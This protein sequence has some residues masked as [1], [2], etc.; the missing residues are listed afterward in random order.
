LIDY[1]LPLVSAWTLT[2]HHGG[3][4]FVADE[5][6]QTGDVWPKKRTVD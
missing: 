4:I 2:N 1:L 6:S 5:F 3:C